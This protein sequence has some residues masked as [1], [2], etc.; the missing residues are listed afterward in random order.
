M[1][2]GRHV[3]KHWPGLFGEDLGGK[4]ALVSNLDRAMPLPKLDKEWP[5]P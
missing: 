5:L 2:M 4:H 1:I 3:P